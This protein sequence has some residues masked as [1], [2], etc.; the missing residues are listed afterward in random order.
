MANKKNKKFPGGEAPPRS[1]AGEP[2]MSMPAKKIRPIKEEMDRREALGLH[3]LQDEP[4][5]G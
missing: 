1:K 5:V 4:D 3:G 2:R